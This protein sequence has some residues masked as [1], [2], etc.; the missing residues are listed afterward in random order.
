[1]GLRVAVGGCACRYAPLPV[2]ARRDVLESVGSEVRQFLESYAC[3][4]SLQGA[5]NCFI[6]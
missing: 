6:K 2:A 4:A 1:M 5:K 3:G